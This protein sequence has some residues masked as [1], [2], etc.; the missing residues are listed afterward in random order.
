[1][2]KIDNIDAITKLIDVNLISKIEA[3]IS[4]NKRLSQ[5]PDLTEIKIL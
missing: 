4:I 1:M 3:F 5:D 2:T